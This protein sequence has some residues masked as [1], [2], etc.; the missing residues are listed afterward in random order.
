MGGLPTRQVAAGPID[1][2][3][4]IR[5]KK[6]GVVK[7]YFIMRQVVNKGYEGWYEGGLTFSPG[8]GY[9]ILGAIVDTTAPADDADKRIKDTLPSVWNRR[10][11]EEGIRG[12]VVEGNFAPAR[13]IAR[14]QGR[15][16]V[17]RATDSLG[18][19]VVGAKV[20]LRKVGGK[21]C[22]NSVTTASGAFT[23]NAPPVQCAGTGAFQLSVSAGGAKS[24]KN[25][26][27]GSA[28]PASAGNDSEEASDAAAEARVLIRRDENRIVIRDR[29]R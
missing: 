17:G 11:V 19:P 3:H 5:G 29:L 26:R 10:I 2:A 28:T 23:V 12:I 1:V 6:V 15:R 25:V 22:C 8:K 14:V 24:S 16:V 20:K 4:V 13:L 18:H 21:T 27:L 7:G 9:P